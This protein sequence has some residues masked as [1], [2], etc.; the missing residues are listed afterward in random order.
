[1]SGFEIAGVVLAVVPLFIEGGKAYATSYRCAREA[2]NHSQ[3]DKKLRDFYDN[4]YW[5]TYELQQTIESV[6][7]QL[8]NLSETR[9]QEV[10]K[11]RNIK[12]CT[13]YWHEDADI[14]EGLK[15]FLASENDLK[16]FL[17]TLN[18][19]LRQFHQL[20]DDKTL[21]MSKKDLSFI[22][23][24]RKMKEFQE[25]EIAGKATS[26]FL[27]RFR[28]AGRTKRREV[29][30]K[31]LHTWNK[32][33]SHVVGYATKKAKK[34][35]IYA[36]SMDSKPPSSKMRALSRKLFMSL[37]KYWR[38]N[39][40]TNHEARVCLA[41][42]GKDL[43][44]SVASEL[45]FHFLVRGSERINNRMWHEMMVMIRPVGWAYSCR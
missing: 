16:T 39:C 15:Q 14:A 29:C 32:R 17:E 40:P 8:P 21:R 27:E 30:L 13:E 26:S 38:C 4:F 22:Q 31:N 6:V 28:F 1:M 9:K 37:S 36:V 25:Q 18:M 3:R 43:P 45:Y 20:V 5:E 33:I 41:T 34:R 12:D 24:Y 7:E 10:L 44:D 11:T 19:V 35:P 23:M 42:C 2:A